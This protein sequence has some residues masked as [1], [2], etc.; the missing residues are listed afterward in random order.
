[1][2]EEQPFTLAELSEF[3]GTEVWLPAPEVRAIG[4]TDG[5]R[6]LAQRAG[7]YWLIDEIALANSNIKPINQALHAE[8]FQVWKLQRDAEGHSANLLVEDG[9]GNEVYRKRIEFTDFPVRTIE[10]WF[11]DNVILLPS[12]Y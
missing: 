9:N 8:E 7:A 12:E 10:L 3:T 11:T 6:Y 2:R 5:V 1:V 4:Y